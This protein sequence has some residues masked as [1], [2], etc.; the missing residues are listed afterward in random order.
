MKP[1]FLTRPALM[2]ALWGMGNP[3]PPPGLLK[4]KEPFFFWWLH[5]K[6]KLAFKIGFVTVTKVIFSLYDYSLTIVISI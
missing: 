2:L 5:K 1:N 3:I 4:Q 6:L